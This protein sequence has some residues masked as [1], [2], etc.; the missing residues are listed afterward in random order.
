MIRRVYIIASDGSKYEVPQD[1]V[2]F[3]RD[4]GHD[5]EWAEGFDLDA[6]CEATIE[7]LPAAPEGEDQP[8]PVVFD[9]FTVDE[10]HSDAS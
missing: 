8:E 1:N 6:F 3:N 2:V 9:H 10:D 4:I 5:F 7:Q